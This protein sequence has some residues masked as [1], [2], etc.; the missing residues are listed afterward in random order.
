[1]AKLSVLL[2]FSYV[3][4]QIID[5]N[6]TP[7]MQHR[8]NYRLRCMEDEE[9]VK[10][11]EPSAFARTGYYDRLFRKMNT[12]GYEDGYWRYPTLGFNANNIPADRPY[13]VYRYGN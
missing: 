3:L 4:V 10:F 6:W 11:G 2:I 13:R 9:P 12:I 7:C 1:M 5:C 8:V